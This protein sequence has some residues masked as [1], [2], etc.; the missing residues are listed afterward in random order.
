MKEQEKKEP[1]QSQP[2]QEDM[3][4]VGGQEKPKSPEKTDPSLVLPLEKLEKIKEQDSPARLF[5]LMEDEKKNTPP[6]NR[7]NW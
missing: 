2:K 6:S 7:K 3:Q 5:Q 1:Q 4:Q